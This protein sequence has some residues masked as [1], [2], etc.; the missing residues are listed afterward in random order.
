MRI[1]V[2]LALIVLPVAAPAAVV[3]D[4]PRA[5][6]Y[7]AAGADSWRT[8]SRPSALPICSS[9]SMPSTA[10]GSMAA[11]PSSPSLSGRISW[12]THCRMAARKGRPG[13]RRRP[14]VSSLRLPDLKVAVV[15]RLVVGDRVISHMRFTGHFTGTFMGHSGAGQPVD[16]IATDILRVRNGR[17]TDNWHLEDNLTFLQQIGV[18]AQ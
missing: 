13:P 4:R 2:V 6:Y 12:I 5:R 17:I 8:T 11:Q 7:P 1:L 14:R 18:V 3:S 10:S 9:R 15:Q 16:F